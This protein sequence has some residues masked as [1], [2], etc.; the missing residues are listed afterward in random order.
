[1]S[2]SSSIYAI[3]PAAGHSRRMGRTKQLIPINGRPMFRAVVENIAAS[4]VT[5]VMVVTRRVIVEAI[6]S[7][8]IDKVHAA[9]NED[10]SSEMIDSIRIGIRAWQERQSIESDAGFLTSP[11]D[12]P[13]LSVQDINSCIHAFRDS[14]T[15][16][17][18]ASFAGRRGH[19]MIFPAALADF[20]LSPACD[21]GLNVLPHAMPNRVKLVPCNSMGVLKDIDTPNDLLSL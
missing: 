9:Y 1:M 19:P 14:S 12:H 7:P 17:V 20:V 6:S 8:H 13:G 15:S 16:I 21:N 11:A 4:D 10:E 2:Q 5:G 3:V 18:I